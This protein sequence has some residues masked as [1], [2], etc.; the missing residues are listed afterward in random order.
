MVAMVFESFQAVF[1]DADVWFEDLDGLLLCFF[2]FCEGKHE[3]V[4][5]IW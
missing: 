5:V 4:A 3:Y 2:S 1:D